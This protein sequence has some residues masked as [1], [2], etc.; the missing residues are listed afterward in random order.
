MLVRPEG[1]SLWRWKG[2]KAIW[3]K[4]FCLKSSMIA[5]VDFFSLIWSMHWNILFRRNLWN[6]TVKFYWQTIRLCELHV[7]YW[8]VTQE[9]TDKMGTKC[10]MVL[11]TGHLSACVIENHFHPLAS[12]V[13]TRFQWHLDLSRTSSGTWHHLS[14]YQ[15]SMFPF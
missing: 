5:H 3:M 12:N 2:A 8:V 15:N 13:Y 6:I 1:W 14:C 10:F 4:K 9:V 11:R 7:K